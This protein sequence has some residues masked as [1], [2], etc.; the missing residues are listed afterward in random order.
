MTG[1]IES[2]FHD[3]ADCTPEARDRYFDEHRVD[4]ETRHEVEALLEFDSGSSAP[5][6]RDIRQAARRA[7]TRFEPGGSLCGAYR[8]S[9]PIGTGGMASVWLADRVDGEVAQT[10]AVKLLRPGVDS[11]VF[12]ARF[13][14]ERQILAGVSHP[15]IARLLDAGHTEY[16]QPY[17]AMEYVAGKPIDEYT[18]RLPVREKIRLF[19]GV[20]SAV[21]YL[22]RNLI[23]HR[24]LKPANI[25]VTAA[26]EPKLLD[27]GI[28]KMLDLTQD[29]TVTSLRILTPD[30]ASPEQV[31]GYPATTAADIYSLGAVLYR[32]LTGR[33]PHSFETRTPEEIIATVRDGAIAPPRKLNP[34]LSRDVE[35]ILLKA[36]RPEPLERY[37]TVDQFAEDLENWLAS[38]PIRVRQSDALYRARKFLRRYWLPTTALM[39]G[40]IGN[41]VGLWV[42]HRERDAAARRFQ[43]VR[44]LAGQ[45]FTI[46]GDIRVLAGSTKAREH[47]VGTA[48][49]YLERLS[50][51]TG[52]DLALKTEIASAYTKVADIQGGFRATSLGRPD[53]ARASLERAQKL[54]RE[55]T[56]ARPRDAA[57]LEGYLRAVEARA[58]IDYGQMNRQGLERSIDELRALAARYEPVA[59]AA[60]DTWDFLGGIYQTLSISAGRLR[61]RADALAFTTR[62]IEFQEK[63]AG[64]A[65]SVRTLGNLA[66]SYSTLSRLQRAEGDLDA[67]LRTARRSLEITE[68]LVK[69][70]PNDGVAR[71][72]LASE[73]GRI[74]ATYAEFNSPSLGNR[75]EAVRWYQRCHDLNG[76]L[77]EADPQENQVRFNMAAMTWKLA[78]IVRGSHP[79]RAIALYDESIALVRAMAPSANQRDA[80]LGFILAESTF[81]LRRVRRNAEAAAR[82]AEARRLADT[83]RALDPASP[84]MPDEAV[85]RADADRALAAGRPA[86]AAAVHE[87]W[88]TA[89]PFAPAKAA[90]DLRGSLIVARHYRLLSDAYQLAG[91]SEAA[92]AAEGKRRA[93]VQLWEKKAPR[94][95]WDCCDAR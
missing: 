56:T 14:E 46:E 21:A 88:L 77:L 48:L 19:L 13:L 28:A 65:R 3:L 45:L 37:A 83:T 24:D 89:H 80:M 87:A 18:D 62:A 90:D 92:A 27:F 66:G 15:N 84:A 81:P 59:P 76:S 63:A 64:A 61:R 4:V 75:D 12:R 85:V 5:L 86:Q 57:A 73:Y 30:Y 11:P 33:S 2:L 36:L 31:A 40:L 16:H 53:D 52:N 67:A 26:G 35:L 47:I 91:R 8:L 22:H 70:Y 50:R 20:C 1:R 9:Q 6:N 69:D 32:L 58:R 42:A 34:A 55:I 72:N 71:L 94:V 51:E 43:E 93:I 39:V 17:L 49:Q 68:Q 41:S 25:L 74:A 78:D 38:R 23:V 79:A 44:Q 60:V 95:A 82:L 54:F 29:S 7:L 10:V